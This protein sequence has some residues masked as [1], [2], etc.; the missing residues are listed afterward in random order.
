LSARA[1]RLQPGFVAFHSNRAEN[2]AEVVASWLQRSPLPP[3]TEEVILVQSN[4]MAEW[5]KMEPHTQT[6][7]PNVVFCLICS[8]VAFG[9]KAKTAGFAY[10]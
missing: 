7:K 10:A 1:P 8:H 5:L 4:G 6:T 3:L 2:L 9:L